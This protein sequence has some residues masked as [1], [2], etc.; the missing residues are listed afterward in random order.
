MSR[1]PAGPPATEVPS[2]APPAARPGEEPVPRR[3]L[4]RA[5]VAP[6]RPVW[7][8]TF[9][10]VV[11]ESH[12]RLRGLSRSQ[13]HLARAGL[14]ML[15]GLLVSVVF[16]DEWRRGDLLAI[17]QDPPVFLPVGLL[18]VTLTAF[19]VAWSLLLWGALAAS[20]AVRL[21]VAALFVLTNATLRVPIS[22]EVNDRVALEW[23]P[24]LVRAGYYLA[25]GALLASVVATVV[26]SL[27]AARLGPPGRRRLR[28]ARWWT[29]LL[30][31]LVVVGLLAFFGS[32]LWIHVVFVQEGFQGSV[33]AMMA[34]TIVEIDGLLLPLVY[35]SAVAVVDFSLD[36]SEGIALSARSV[37]ARLARWLLAALLAVKLWLLLL[38]ELGE[39]AAYVRERPVAVVR[40]VVSLLLLALVVR[41]VTRFAATGAFEIAEERLLY[42][43]S[44]A[45]AMPFIATV[46]AVSFG[47][48]LVSQLQRPELPGFATSFPTERLQQYGLPALAALALAIGLWLWGRGRSGRRGGDRELGSGLVVVTA[49]ALPALLLNLTDWQVGF[50]ERLFD[51]LLTL[52]VAGVLAVR[53]RR[54]D[55]GGVV[56]LAAL[57]VFSW[58]VLSQGDWIAFVGGLVGLSGIVVVVFGVAYSLVGD[59]AFTAGSSRRL[60]QGSRVLLF[61][62]YLVLSVTILHWVEATHSHT[63]DAATQAGFFYLA[64]PIA[65][66]LVGRRLVRLDEEVEEYEEAVEGLG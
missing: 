40:T 17:G 30:R 24:E 53:W 13:L 51:V 4:H 8:A 63:S 16:V 44:V 9:R 5:V 47:V 65:A 12:L 52:G 33:Q 10:D 37:G 25:P 26:A 35:V 54:L 27:V 7:E 31:V 19:L 46:L 57:T 62:G 58:F 29:A 34:G 61:V 66:W 41:L 22:F 20:P 23:G 1:E 60:P 39:W 42:T 32:L 38:D 28:A 48:V 45:L 18:P 21:V 14:V 59:A 55:T 49:W 15:A 2:E 50:S 11:L 56:T 6:V 36:L 64:I 3:R 43:C